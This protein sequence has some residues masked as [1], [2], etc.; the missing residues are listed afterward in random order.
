MHSSRINTHHLRKYPFQHVG[1]LFISTIVP[2]LNILRRKLF[3]FSVSQW[4]AVFGSP[5]GRDFLFQFITALRVDPPFPPPKQ[6]LS[7]FNTLEAR[8]VRKQRS[9]VTAQS[10]KPTPLIADHCPADQIVSSHHDRNKRPD[11]GPSPQGP[12]IGPLP[13]EPK[14]RSKSKRPPGPSFGLRVATF[15]AGKFHIT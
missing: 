11:T 10:V 1:C 3:L 13:V 15:N 2:A 7:R 8:D 5:I 9:L 14:L 6:T 4:F 12:N